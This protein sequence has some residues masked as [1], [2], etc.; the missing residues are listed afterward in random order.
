[1]FKTLNLF[2]LDLSL[3]FSNNIPFLRELM[4]GSE[5]MSR[6]NLGEDLI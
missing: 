5:V 3:L 2:I 4:M 6:E 1:M